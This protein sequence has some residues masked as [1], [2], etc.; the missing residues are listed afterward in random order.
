MV[1]WL[2]G[3]SGAGKTTIGNA[4]Y[5]QVKLNNDATV[6]VD[7]DG[8]RSIFKHESQQDYSLEGR[9]ISAERLQQICLW[10]DKQGIDVICCNLGIFDDINRNN[11]EIFTDYKE[12]LIDVAIDTLIS[13]DN[14]FLYKSALRGEQKHVVGIDIHYTPPSSPDLI[15]KNSQNTEDVDSYVEKI[16]SVCYRVMKLNTYPYSTGPLLNS[17]QSYRYT[18]YLG[19]I[20]IFDWQLSRTSYLNQY[21]SPCTSLVSSEPSILNEHHTN[22]IAAKD[23]LVRLCLE[24]RADSQL[25]EHVDYWLPRMLKKFEVSKRLFQFYKTNAPHSAVADSRYD[26]LEL[27]LL[28]AEALIRA[29]AKKP[30]SQYV[31]G[32]LKLIDTLLSQNL[33]L[34]QSQSKYLGWL[35]LAEQ[36]ILDKILDHLNLKKDKSHSIVALKCDSLSFLNFT[37][38]KPIRYDDDSK[39]ERKSVYQ[40][41]TK[42]NKKVLLL[43]GHTT[44]TVAYIQALSNA[45]IIPSHTIVYGE[46]KTKFISTRKHRDVSFDGMFIPNFELDT[47]QS[48]EHYGL[49]FSV[50]QEQELTSPS[51]LALINESAPDLIIYSGYGG[52]IVPESILNQFP[53]LHIHSGWLPEYRGSTTLYYQVIDE[54]ICAA[55]AILLDEKIDTGGIVARKRYA[56]PLKGIDVD[57]LYDNTIRADLLIQTLNQWLDPSQQWDITGQTQDTLPY[58]IIHPLLKHLALLKID[59]EMVGL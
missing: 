41:S 6:L 24:L 26:D 17:T 53:V 47:L 3:L 34:S 23:I 59:Q 45:N 29:W 33:Q 46:P 40:S 35:T 16:I 49:P 38:I 25:S 2:I 10:L 9:R 31:N 18:P 58:F 14:K 37:Q 43:C 28:L 7:G 50:T 19:S 8:M 30:L 11:R 36:M 20:F 54:N 42:K 39:T 5:Q 15:I 57:Y 52:Q 13:R 44:R 21:S 51:L 55:S 12:V 22:N 1:I 48:L 56:I 27:Y 32:L 4:L